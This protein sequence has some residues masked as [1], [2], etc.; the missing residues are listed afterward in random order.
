MVLYCLPSVHPDC[1]YNWRMIGSREHCKF[2]STPFIYVNKAGLYQCVI[3]C[4][5][6]VLEGRIISVSVEVGRFFFFL[7][8]KEVISIHNVDSE[9]QGGGMLSS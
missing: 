2:P 1:I 4:D 3:T 8:V 7:V 5:S 6:K 9:F